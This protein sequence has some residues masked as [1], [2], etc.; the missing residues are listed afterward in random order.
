M[1]FFVFLNM[2]HIQE[3]SRNQ[4]Q[5]ERLEDKI[6]IN[7]PVHFIDAF[8]RLYRIQKSGFEIKPLIAKLKARNKPYKRKGLF[9]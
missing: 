5:M 8:F 1:T 2:Q 3:V 4:L 6:S 9:L 7:N